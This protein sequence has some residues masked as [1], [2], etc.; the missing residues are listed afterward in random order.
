MHVLAKCMPLLQAQQERHT[1]NLLPFMSSGL[2]VKEHTC[3][4]WAPV[5]KQSK[6]EEGPW[7]VED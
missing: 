7:M 6:S 2:L 1:H 4:Q 5:K 3:K